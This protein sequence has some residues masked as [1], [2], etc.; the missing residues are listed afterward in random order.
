MKPVKEK[1]E[2]KKKAAEAKKQKKDELPKKRF[3]EKV[4]NILELPKDVV[5]NIPRL[6]II[7]NGSVMIENYKG[8][9]EYESTRVRINTNSGIIKIS[10]SRLSIKEMTDEDLILEGQIASLEFMK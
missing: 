7:G 8:I 4:T 2:L 1:K 5:L 6:T 9:I 3:K 10:G